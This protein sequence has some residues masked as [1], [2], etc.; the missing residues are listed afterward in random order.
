MDGN[1]CLNWLSHVKGPPQ[2]VLNGLQRVD[3]MSIRE[4]SPEHL[5]ELFHHYHQALAPDFGGTSAAST[6]AWARVPVQEKNRLVAAGAID[7]TGIVVS[8]EQPRGLQT[9]F[10]EA[11][12]S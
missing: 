9:I 4:V 7:A 11:R 2:L 8:T 5:A 10:R 1:E 12:R 3:L 6:Q